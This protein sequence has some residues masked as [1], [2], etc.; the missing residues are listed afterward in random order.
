MA[1][2]TVKEVELRLSLDFLMDLIIAVATG[3][4]ELE[5]SEVY[6]FTDVSPVMVKRKTT[7]FRVIDK[8]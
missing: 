6:D 5:I 3:K 2:K 7:T 1:N 8:P 4:K